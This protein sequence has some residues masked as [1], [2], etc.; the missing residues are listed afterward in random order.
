MKI[1]NIEVEFFGKDLIDTLQKNHEVDSFDVKNNNELAQLLKNDYEV[2]IAKIGIE[3]DKNVIDQAG[4]LKYILSPTTG[5]NHIDIDYCKEKK[6]NI[7]N[8]ANDKNILSNVTSTAE[9]AFGL[10]LNLSRSIN[11]A[12]DTVK[13]NQWQRNNFTR[14]ELRNSTLGIL[15]VG[16]LGQMVAEYAQ[17]FGMRIIG[18]DLRDE[19]FNKNSY[20]IRGTFNDILQE[21]DIISI[22]LPYNS[23]T[24]KI[25]CKEKLDLC[26]RECYLVNTAR[27][28]LIDEDYLIY[29]LESNKIAGYA[30]DVLWGDSSWSISTGNSK[31]IDYCK[32]SNK[33]LITPHIGG[34]GKQS[35][36]LVREWLIYKFNYYISN[37]N[38]PDENE[39][40][41]NKE[42]EK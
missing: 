1:L 32:S 8:V 12:Y 24:H 26:K 17:A 40:L 28:E 13:N 31:L 35:I 27:G 15:G 34:M 4:S 2:L 9:L 3:V 20:L 25:L 39:W 30:T 19:P 11:H 29:L 16:R 6:I 41:N 36:E 18:C 38:F 7:I 42:K 37:G 22:H 5:L 33:V 23:K 10:I 14:L 21:S